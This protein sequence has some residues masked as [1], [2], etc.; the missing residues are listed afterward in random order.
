MAQAERLPIY[1]AKG[2]ACRA[3]PHLQRR[4][5]VRSGVAAAGTLGPRVAAVL[6]VSAWLAVSVAPGT[7]SA[8]T[9]LNAAIDGG[10]FRCSFQTQNGVNY[11]VQFTDSLLPAG[12]QTLTNLTGNGSSANIAD[13]AQDLFERFY[14]VQTQ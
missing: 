8:V 1:N 3:R 12:W 4:V 9:I 2:P 11:T 14:R 10:Q 7:N 6:V 5:E 13:G